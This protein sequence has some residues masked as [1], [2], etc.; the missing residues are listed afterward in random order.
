M[1]TNTITT[2]NSLKSVCSTTVMARKLALSRSRFYDLVKQGVF[3]RPVNCPDTSH[4]F[5][6][7]ELQQQCLQVKQTGIGINGKPV[8]FYTSRKRST[9]RKKSADDIDHDYFAMN[10]F[11]ILKNM[12]KTLSKSQLRDILKAMYPNGLPE[13]PIDQVELKK[14]FNFVG[15]KHKN[16][17]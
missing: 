6:T 14:I 7:L 16:D 3:P 8:L 12:G 15:G 10:L 17:V 5:Y 11:G 1:K 4:L 9:G 13:W 2:E